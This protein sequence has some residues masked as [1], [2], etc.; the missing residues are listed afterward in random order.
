M[1]TTIKGMYTCKHIAKNNCFW[2]RLV[3]RDCDFILKRCQKIE[4]TKNN[5]SGTRTEINN[6]RLIYISLFSID[7]M[8]KPVRERIS[9]GKQGIR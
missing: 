4:R 7:R 5:T 3:A 1:V 8:K 6:A 9:S 2:S